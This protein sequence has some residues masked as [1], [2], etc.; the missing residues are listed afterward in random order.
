MKLS[1]FANLCCSA[2]FVAALLVC[3]ACLGAA[4]AKSE[5]AASAATGTN[6]APQEP[7]LLSVFDV[8]GSPSVKDPFYPATLRSP[9]PVV[10]SAVTNV[11]AISA[12]SFTLKGLSGAI[13]QRLAIINN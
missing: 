3:S 1:R 10:N 2:C 8:T 9:T 6:A 13:G 12:S 4:P 11:T 5:V 7:V